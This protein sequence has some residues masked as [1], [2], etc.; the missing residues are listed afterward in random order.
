L[1]TWVLDVRPADGGAEAIFVNESGSLI[2]GFVKL[3]YPA[4]LIPKGLSAEEL[5]ELVAQH[6]GVAEVWVEVW[7]EPPWYV[8]EVP[9]VK[10]VSKNLRT[11]YSV[12]RRA[13][14]LGVGERV[15]AYPNPL[16]QA[17]REAGMNPCSMVD[18]RGWVTVEDLSNPLYDPPPYRIA[19]L[20]VNT[21]GKVFELRL[22]DEV[23]RDS[24]NS[25][26]EYAHVIN[27]THI[28]VVDGVTEPQLRDYLGELRTPVKV[29]R[30]VSL[31]GVAG[32]IEW[33][34]ISWIPLRLLSKAS[35]GEVLTTAE[36]FKAFRRR[37]LVP[38]RVGRVEAFR[39]LRD[40]LR[41]DRGGSVL[42]PEVGVYFNVA[43]LDFNSLY[44][45]LIVKHNVSPE[46]VGREGCIN[47]FRVPEV[48]HLVCQD[49][50]GVVPEALKELVSRREALRE[51]LKS[52]NDLGLKD[53][54]NERQK[55]LKWVLVASFG[56]LGYRN[57]RFGK[58]EAYESVT[59]LARDALRRAESVA[60][61][62]GF[63]V[64][65]ALVDSIFVQEVSD[66]SKGGCDEGR[67]LKLAK[68]IA[69]EVGVGMK[70]EAI[71]DWVAFPK[72]REGRASPMKYFGR[73]RDGSLK[74]KG[75]KA[76]NSSTPEVVREAQLA[77]LMELAKAKDLR[78]LRDALLRAREIID[79]YIKSVI[80]GEVSPDSLVIRRRLRK[81]LST[82]RSRQPHVR[83]ARIA[84]VNSGI[85][86]YV[87]SATPHPPMEGSRNYSR[88]YY[89]KA[90]KEA[91]NEVASAIT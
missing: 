4:Y 36:A 57:S 69:G 59:A 18:L 19:E 13:E 6:P 63:R 12:V 54:L 23:I 1:R 15:N 34:R 77:V 27:S 21:Y 11:L 28:L 49:L 31:T 47:Y 25:L 37:Y 16:T 22:N 76:I 48:N 20:S 40:L 10:F 83:A 71:Y 78:S 56:Y 60:E 38:E 88:N 39:S 55:A 74:I 5:A 62:E 84:G 67:Y 65:H 73:L 52:V 82:Y 43:Q 14:E 50:V 2:K 45:S 81:P 89:V 46:T 30:E 7:R 68:E 42:T 51:A 87:M 17:L 3:T 29:F 61:R 33:C 58:I 86:A 72:T 80:D 32:L 70:V 9:V 26:G 85:I 90:I 64:I 35:I 79:H 75:M 44:P 66:N 8:S 24:L 41:A 53:L 91:F